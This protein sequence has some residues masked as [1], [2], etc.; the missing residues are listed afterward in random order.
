MKKI[1]FLLVSLLGITACSSAQDKRMES[2]DNSTVTTFDLSRFMGRWYEIARYEHRFE[3]GMT[4][5]TATYT[6]PRNV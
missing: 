2:L 3:K 1:F 5:V 6:L 4:H